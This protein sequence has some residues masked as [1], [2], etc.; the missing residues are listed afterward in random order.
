MATKMVTAN[1]PGIG[2][3]SIPSTSVASLPKGSTMSTSTSTASKTTP[4]TPTTKTTTTPTKTTSTSSSKAQVMPSQTQSNLQ[5]YST[6]QVGADG[7]APTGLSAGTVVRTAGGDFKITGV[8]ADGSYEKAQVYNDPARVAL[9]QSQPKTNSITVPA[10]TTTTPIASTTTPTQPNLNEVYK[11]DQTEL[12]KMRAMILQG[13]NGGVTVPTQ[14][15]T[16]T[17]NPTPVTQP[18]QINTPKPQELIQKSPVDQ[19]RISV[20]N[21]KPISN[22]STLINNSADEYR[23]QILAG[24][25]QSADT[26]VNNLNQQKAGLTSQYYDKRNQADTVHIQNSA[27]LKELMGNSGL[28]GSGEN[29][30]AQTNLLGARQ[31]AQSDLYRQEQLQRDSIDNSITNTRNAMSLEEIKAIAEIE[32]NRSSDLL[33][34]QNKDIAQ[35]RQDSINTIGA[36]NDDY[37]AQIEKIMNDNDTS[38]DYL[39]PYLKQ[40]RQEKIQNQQATDIKNVG[41]YGNDYQ[42]EIERRMAINPNDPVIPALKQARQE[43]IANQ[44]ATSLAN[45]EYVTVDY[46]GQTIR[47]KAKDYMDMSSGQ[48]LDNARIEEIQANIKNDNAKTN[49]DINKPYY[50]PESANSS[51]ATVKATT[52]YQRATLIKNR[53]NDY[54][55]GGETPE[56]AYQLATQDIDNALN[57]TTPTAKPTKQPIA[58]GNSWLD[59]IMKGVSQGVQRNKTNSTTTSKYKTNIGNL[60]MAEKG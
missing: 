57:G 10:K 7:K 3:V 15:Q 26:Q 19:A 23:K 4:T 44:Q 22:A 11:P 21:Q 5:G 8:N 51:N 45:Q 50:N 27:R 32:K 6:V 12:E 31:G 30:T 35:S 42:A 24:I 55:K 49:Y 14:S 52:P 60:E 36:Y 28:L 16:S 39:I 37:Q 33:E 20:L 53:T 18:T 38:N 48:A 17:I 54:I 41:Q 46:Q 2:K 58:T 40:A 13:S 25:K 47:M 34:Q 56:D 59:S 29:L 43:K 9:L 1:I